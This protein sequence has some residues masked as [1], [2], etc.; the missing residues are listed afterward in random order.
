VYAGSLKTLLLK[1]LLFCRYLKYTPEQAQT[2]KHVFLAY[3][4]PAH[5]NAIASDEPSRASLLSGA[6]STLANGISRKRKTSP[7]SPAAGSVRKEEET[8]EEEGEKEERRKR[9]ARKPE[10]PPRT[11][12][13][14]L[15]RTRT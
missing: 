7:A 12:R 5:Y 9:S 3:I 6:P 10:W 14:S 4:A 1:T 2:E 11:T 8:E 13:H 15:K